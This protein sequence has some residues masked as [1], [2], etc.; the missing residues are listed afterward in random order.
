MPRTLFALLCPASIILADL[1]FNLDPLFRQA[2][3][4]DHEDVSPDSFIL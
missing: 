1:L 2:T 4:P 3:Q